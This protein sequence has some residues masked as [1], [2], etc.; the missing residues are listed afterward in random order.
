MKFLR[1]SSSYLSLIVLIFF[2]SSHVVALCSCS[3]PA[4][5]VAYSRADAVFIGKLQKL[6]DDENLID[7]T[8]A[9]FEVEK[10]FKGK[11]GKVEVVKLIQGDCGATFKEGEKYFVYKDNSGYIRPCNRTHK[12]SEVLSKENDDFIYASSLTAANPTFTISGKIELLSES[13]KKNVKVLIEDGKS[14]YEPEIDAYGA[15]SQKVTKKR[16][17]DVKI[18]L[19]FDAAIEVTSGDVGYDVKVSRSENQTII[20]YKV[21]FKPN[22]CEDREIKFAKDYKD[23]TKF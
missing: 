13:E 1:F 3:I 15:F 23:A 14:K 17:Y 5:C 20:S 10:I 6:V 8:Y 19:P 4:P 12:F 11:V 2:S 21:E 16:I 22:S 7:A 18:M 9:Y